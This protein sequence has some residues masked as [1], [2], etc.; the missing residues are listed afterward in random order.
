MYVNVWMYVSLLCIMNVNEYEY[1]IDIDIDNTIAQSTIHFC[2]K[3]IVD[4]G[5][6]WGNC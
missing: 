4:W 5:V 2:C 3:Y 1:D 6:F